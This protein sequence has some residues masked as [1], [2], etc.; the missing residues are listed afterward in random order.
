[1]SELEKLIAA[2]V[3][4]QL[5][6]AEATK[7]LAAIS[8]AK[9]RKVTAAQWRGLILRELWTLVIDSGESKLDKVVL[10]WHYIPREDTPKSAYRISQDLIRDAAHNVG[11]PVKFGKELIHVYDETIFITN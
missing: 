4:K 2:E 8:H 6:A 1:M 10:A 3:T 9:R 5:A 11:A 7:Q